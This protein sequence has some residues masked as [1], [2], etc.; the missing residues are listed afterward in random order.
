M[1]MGKLSLR[2]SS[3]SGARQMPLSQRRELLVP[4]CVI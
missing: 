3:N 1:R 2:M 4:L